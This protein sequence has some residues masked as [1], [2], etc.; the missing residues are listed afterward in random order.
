[1][2]SLPRWVACVQ[3]VSAIGLIILASACHRSRVAAVAPAPAAQPSGP[4]PTPPGPPS[5]TLTAEPASVDMG[6]SVTLTWTSENATTLD[7][8]PGLGKQLP[9]GSVS[10]TP[11][12]SITYTG[13]VT[14]AA[15]TAKCE[16][17]VTVAV[18]PPSKPS[19]KESTVEAAGAA[20][21]QDAFFD[22]DKSDLRDDAKAA[23]TADAAYLKAHPD[24]KVKVEGHCDQRGSEEYN[25]GLG[26]RRATAAKNFLSALG[27]PDERLSSV[28]YGKDKPLCTEM[29][30]EC[31][32]KNR[33]AHLVIEA[34]GTGGR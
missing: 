3:C 20:A 7:I 24:V 28:S 14:G 34:A 11:N 22:L 30:E 12:E 25:L 16:A 21:M 9:Q 6:K 4:P 33:R 1:M 15:G 27:I 31:W 2:K 10:V 17:R 32:S 18:A 23:L 13:N 19:V 5:C 26:D 8:E 29:S